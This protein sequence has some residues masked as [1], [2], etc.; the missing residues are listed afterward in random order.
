MCSGKVGPDW[1]HRAGKE[2]EATERK[3]INFIRQRKRIFSHICS[4]V[5]ARCAARQGAARPQRATANALRLT[6]RARARVCTLARPPYTGTRANTRPR[7]RCLWSERARARAAH[8]AHPSLTRACAGRS[9]SA[10]RCTCLTRASMPSRSSS[11]S[12]CER[13]AAQGARACVCVCVPVRGRVLACE[14]ARVRGRVRAHA[15]M[16]ACALRHMGVCEC[17]RACMGARA[18]MRAWARFAP[19]GC[20]LVG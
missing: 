11:R 6:S 8:P 17:A 18:C 16:R 14:H 15:C 5:R 12:V 19:R 2:S 20:V 4:A 13:S 1:P 7:A 10:R 3:T 9:C